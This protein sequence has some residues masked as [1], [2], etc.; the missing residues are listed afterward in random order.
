MN[1]TYTRRPMTFHWLLVNMG[2]TASKESEKSTMRA[3]LRYRVS[4]RSIAEGT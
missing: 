3:I 2:M 4:R 1:R